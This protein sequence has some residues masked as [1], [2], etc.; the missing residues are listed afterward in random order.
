[1]KTTRRAIMCVSRQVLEELLPNFEK[2]A[3]LRYGFLLESESSTPEKHAVLT[4]LFHEALKLPSNC[5]IVTI[6][7]SYRFMYDEVAFLIE[8][9]DFVETEEACVMPEVQAVYQSQHDFTVKPGDWF[10]HGTNKSFAPDQLVS[11]DSSS[12]FLRWEGPAVETKREYGSGGEEVNK[13]EECVEPADLRSSVL[14]DPRS[15]VLPECVFTC[16]LDGI[17]CLVSGSWTVED[18]ST[19]IAGQSS[20]ERIT[21]LTHFAGRVITGGITTSRWWPKDD[22]VLQ[23]GTKKMVVRILTPAGLIKSNGVPLDGATPEDINK[24]I[25]ENL[26]KIQ[27]PAVSPQLPVEEMS[28]ELRFDQPIAGSSDE[29]TV[30]FDWLCE[31]SE[32]C[33]R[34]GSPTVRRLP[35]GIAECQ[36]CAGKSLL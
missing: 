20:G 21:S 22:A 24:A 17:K 10:D 18:L 16:L 1:M 2:M 8:C 7:T 3:L 26:V 29:S 27:I 6:N 5:H 33:W 30:D 34:C 25:Q 36:E 14:P 31:G 19:S 32:S 9:P 4:A 12:Y 28:A 23:I 15:S 13:L 11:T 35:D